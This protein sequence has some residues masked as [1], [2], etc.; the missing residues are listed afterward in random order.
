[1]SQSIRAAGTRDPA[2]PP[3]AIAGSAHV[4]ADDRCEAVVLGLCR[5][6][7]VATGDRLLDL[8]GHPAVPG[9]ATALGARVSA[10]DAQGLGR[11]PRRRGHRTAPTHEG[12]DFDAVLCCAGP[13]PDEDPRA[14]ADGLVLATRPGGRIG[15]IWPLEA[16]GSGDAPSAPCRCGWGPVRRGTYERWRSEP[17]LV[18]LFGA[19]ALGI[20]VMRGEC[21]CPIEAEPARGLRTTVRVGYIETLVRRA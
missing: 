9:F 19:Y 20:A 12:G 21:T 1:M 13:H 3:R 15:L 14:W 5:R 2:R 7:I 6:L 16:G 4:T 11:I 17:G 18:A 8:S 10:A